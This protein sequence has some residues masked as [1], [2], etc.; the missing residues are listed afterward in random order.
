M[1]KIKEYLTTTAASR[2]LE[3]IGAEIETQFVDSAGKPISLSRS[4]QMLEILS[5]EKWQIAERKGK[6]IT[7][8]VD[9]NGHRLLYELGRHNIE[10]AAAPTTVKDLPKILRDCLGQL[11]RA[12]ETVGAEPYFAPILP[13]EE[14]LLVI[15]DERDADWLRLDG[16]EALRPLSRISSVQFTISVRT[17]EAVDILNRLGERIGRFLDDFPQDI[18][19]KEYIA[20]SRAGYLP[21]RYGGPPR[22]ES[23]DEY[24]RLLARH[25]PVSKGRLSSLER[26]SSTE[27]PLYLRSVWWHFRLK[28]YEKSLCVE[29]RPLARRTDRYWEER[30]EEIL[31]II[32]P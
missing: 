1:R 20:N 25:R 6:M 29:I 12:A 14:D 8:L 5:C 27:I 15:P 2:T 13:G 31:T 24:C 11:Y 28:R 7:A 19:W 26:L 18:I 10:L 9:R 32:R 23:L 3:T 16:R 30:L 17:E 4:Q 22:F 21:D